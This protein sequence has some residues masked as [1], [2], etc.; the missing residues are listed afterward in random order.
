MKNEDRLRNEG[1]LSIEERRRLEE[2]RHN[3]VVANTTSQGID[4]DKP[5]INSS[6]GDIVNAK[7]T[8]RT[9]SFDQVN[10]DYKFVMNNLNKENEAFRQSKLEKT[11]AMKKYEKFEKSIPKARREMLERIKEKSHR[12]A[13]PQQKER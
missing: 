7:E 6:D 1:A 13:N 11:D 12:E 9:K 4:I 8:Q 2:T 3:S 5:L 10:A